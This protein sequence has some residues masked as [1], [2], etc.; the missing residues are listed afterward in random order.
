[1]SH[2]V[3]AAGVFSYA[4]HAFNGWRFSAAVGIVQA[5]H[6]DAGKAVFLKSAPGGKRTGLA[7]NSRESAPD[8]AQGAIVFIGSV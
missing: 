2:I 5:A 1:M 4:A 7:G 8:A 6:D 3:Y